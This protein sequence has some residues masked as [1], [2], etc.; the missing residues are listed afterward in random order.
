MDK[1]F[2]ELPFYFVYLDDI[3]VF[4]NSLAD[5][6]LHLCRMLDCC[7]LHR[8]TINLKKCVF[9]A[10]QVKYLS[11]S[12]SSSGYS[13]LLKHVSAISAFPLTTL[14]CNGSWEC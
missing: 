8:L 10:F 11:H 5:H 1:I 6:Q 3:L 7:H 9:A 2:V 14:P 12:V 4:P 13:P